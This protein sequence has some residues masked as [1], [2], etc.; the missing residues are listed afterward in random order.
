[1]FCV[2]SMIAGLFALFIVMFATILDQLLAAYMGVSP[3]IA[4]FEERL[5]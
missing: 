4:A 1:M 2:L 5:T 3:G